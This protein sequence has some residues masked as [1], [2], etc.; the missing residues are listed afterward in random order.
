MPDSIRED[1]PYFIQM[2]GCINCVASEYHKEKRGNDYGFY[3][4]SMLDCIIIHNCG[5]YTFRDKPISLDNPFYDTEEIV[6][7]AKK[8]GTEKII[9]GSI[10]LCQS[11]NETFGEFY[12]V[13][14]IS[15]DELIEELRSELSD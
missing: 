4:M 8:H 5:N 6:R 12:K 9:K 15:I 7:F 1:I 14:D 10:K 3:P 2:R 11:I 13:L